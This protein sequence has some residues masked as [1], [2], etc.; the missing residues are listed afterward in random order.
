LERLDKNL[1]KWDFKIN[2]H[3]WCITNKMIDGKQCTVLWHMDDIKVSH[4]N[5]KVVSAV[6][7]PFEERYGKE[8]LLTVTR[9][10]KKQDYLGMTLDYSVDGK[11][12]ILMIDYIK[13]MSAEIPENVSR[14]APTPA[15]NHLSQ[16]NKDADKLDE[17][18]AQHFHHNVVKLLFLCK[19]ARPDV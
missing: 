9:G 8:A 2:P 1:K 13:K 18:L 11:V 3:D 16:V 19:W 17:E 4:K 15:V 7:E 14:E 6:L 10:N 5:P 12:Q